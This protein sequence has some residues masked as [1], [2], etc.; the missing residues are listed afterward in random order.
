VILD[1]PDYVAAYFDDLHVHPTQ[2]LSSMCG[3]GV[4]LS[5]EVVP[6]ISRFNSRSSRSACLSSALSRRMGVEWFKERLRRVLLLSEELE[7]AERELREHRALP[8]E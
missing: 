8:Y 1:F 7:R 4:R 2:R 3:F 6:L 5:F